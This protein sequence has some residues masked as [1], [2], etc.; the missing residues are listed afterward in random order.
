MPDMNGY[1]AAQEMKKLNPGV[2]VVLITGWG[3]DVDQA[4]IRLIGI[5]RVVAK[6]FLPEDLLGAMEEAIGRPS[7]RRQR[8][9]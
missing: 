6:P 9:T 5:H 1:Q 3:N 7:D 8:R 2:P 4:R